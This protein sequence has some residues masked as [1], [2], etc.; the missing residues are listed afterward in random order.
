MRC[1]HLS[2]WL[3]RRVAGDG[4]LAAVCR[5][6][7]WVRRSVVSRRAKIQYRHLDFT[8]H[9]PARCRVD[10]DRLLYF[11]QCYHS[12]REC[13]LAR[14][15]QFPR[16]SRAALLKSV[17]VLVVVSPP[18]ILTLPTLPFAQTAKDSSKVCRGGRR[19]PPTQSRCLPPQHT[20]LILL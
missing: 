16:G 2:T 10:E 14:S 11:I 7:S 15:G 1:R 4:P 13:T 5:A 17:S 9:S 12:P 19:P 6:Y 18:F 20:L 8:D 3:Q